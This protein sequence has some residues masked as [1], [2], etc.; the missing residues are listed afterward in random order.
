MDENELND[1]L[2]WRDEYGYGETEGEEDADE[3]RR[4]ALTQLKRVQPPV[5]LKRATIRSSTAACPDCEEFCRRVNVHFGLE[6]FL[7]PPLEDWF[8]PRK[9]VQFGGEIASGSFATVYLGKRHETEVVVKCFKIDGQSDCD[10]RTFLR[11]MF[12]SEV[13]VWRRARHPHIVHF[14]G[15]YHDCSSWFIVSEY[16]PGGTLPNYLYKHRED[17]RLLVWR[18]LLD[19][20]LGLHFLHEQKIVHSDLKGNNIL[21]SKDGTAM[22]SD[23]GLSFE[24]FGSRANI[25]KW[26]AIRWRP[27]EYVLE[28][29]AGPS[30]AGDVYSLGMCI[31]EA[32]TG[33][34]PWGSIADS[35]VK[36]FLR[37]KENHLMSRPPEL[38]EPE[39][40]LVERMCAFEPSARMS[41]AD[42]V[43]QLEDVVRQLE[44]LA[45]KQD[46][47]ERE[48]QASS[49]G[50]SPSSIDH[51]PRYADS[52]TRLSSASE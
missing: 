34:P 50:Q 26:G 18:K 12:L 44:D 9:E 16:A 22:L 48:N 49:S 30:F 3:E 25:E 46:K 33:Q 10:K 2:L 6:L 41:I 35:Q 5:C 31:V 7:Q 37:N 47:L 28:N 13:R 38:S 43:R 4:I 39:W 52:R 45:K 1:L 24:Q 11:E 14:L 40:E 20:A 19:V 23:F 27:P 17:N 51:R 36:G 21:V 29:G 15:A 8:I 32:V 42:V